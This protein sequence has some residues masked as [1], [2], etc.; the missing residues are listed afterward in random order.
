VVF[1]LLYFQSGYFKRILALHFIN[2]KV[3]WRAWEANA[4]FASKLSWP[5]R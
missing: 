5:R 3:F 2:L 4:E 1:Q